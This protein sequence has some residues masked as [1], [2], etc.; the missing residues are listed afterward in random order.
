MQMFVG[1]MDY[2]LRAKVFMYSRLFDEG[3]R[4]GCIPLIEAVKV[5]DHIELVLDKGKP[6]TYIRGSKCG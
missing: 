3:R 5:C 4:P 2:I 1:G 6:K